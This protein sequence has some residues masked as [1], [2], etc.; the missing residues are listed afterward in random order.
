MKLTTGENFKVVYQGDYNA[1]ESGPDFLNAKVEID[2]LLW[3]GN[4]ELHVRSKD[5]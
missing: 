4:V 5:W 3:V 1:Y 2:G